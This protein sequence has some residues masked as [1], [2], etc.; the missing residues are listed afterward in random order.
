[1]KNL[2]IYNFFLKPV[3]LDI[4]KHFKLSFIPPLL[5]YLA[6]G[7]SSITGIVGIF[8]IKDYLNLSA[9]FLAGLG[10][11]AGIPWALKMPL[12]HVV[13]LI[14]TRKNILIYI[15]AFLISVSLI[16]MYLLISNTEFMVKYLSAEKWFILSTILSPVGYVLQDV[17]ADAMTVE[18]VPKY[19]KNQKNYTDKEIK[20]M[21]TT[22]QTFGRFS[23]IGGTVLVAAVN[24]YFFRDASTLN[25]SQKIILYSNIYLYALIIPIIS[26]LGVIL[27]KIILTN[28]KINIK[29]INPDYSIIIGSLVFVI[30]ISIVGLLNHPMSQEIVFFGSL[31]IVIFLMK[32]LLKKISPNIKN[33]IVGTAIAIFAFRSVPSIGAGMSWFEIDILGFDQGFFSLLS[34][35]S[36]LLTMAGIIFFRKFMYENTIVKIIIYLSFLNAILLLPSLSMYYGFHEWTSA[37]TNDVI[38]VKFIAIINTALES[39]LGQVA[40]IPMLAWIAKNAPYNLKATF[41]AVFASFTN[42]ALSASN[43]LTKYLNKIFVV[44]RDVKDKFNQNILTNANYEELGVL[45]IVVILTTFLL[46]YLTILLI[47][48]TKFKTNE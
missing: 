20:A 42:L 23:I 35:I 22:M 41:F 5:I 14:W 25:D 36:S 7:V 4:S 26:I 46:P 40:M 45:I 12:G 11:W 31:M 3:F 34:L 29:K 24:I 8:F 21:H 16:I 6:A 32:N 37:I 27:S 17:V 13:D 38:N 19:N 1:M 30:F 15:G 44:T 33:T 9:A 47:Q 43:L 2:L 39:P 18:A 48:K 28:N 10:F